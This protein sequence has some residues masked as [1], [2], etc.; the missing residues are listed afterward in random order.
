VVG[1]RG[2]RHLAELALVDLGAGQLV[3]LQLLGGDG[4]VL[5]DLAVDLRDGV[6]GA[7]QRDEQREEG[8]GHRGGGQSEPGHGATVRLLSGRAQGL[9]GG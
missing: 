5:E 8:H 3:L 2:G 1:L 7:T 9:T 6:A 4:S